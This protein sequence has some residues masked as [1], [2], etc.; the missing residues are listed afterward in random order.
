MAMEPNAENFDAAGVTTADIVEHLFHRAALLVG[1]DNA[2]LVK[3]RLLSHRDDW[4]H[5]AENLL[6]YC[7]LDSDKKPPQKHTRT[8]ED[9]WHR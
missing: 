4:A 1:K 9:G 6:R 3:D 7:W 5:L 8:F 2:D